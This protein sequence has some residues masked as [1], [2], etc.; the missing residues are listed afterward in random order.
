MYSVKL[1]TKLI[2]DVRQVRQHEEPCFKVLAGHSIG[3]TGKPI[4]DGHDS[5]VKGWTRIGTSQ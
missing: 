4:K 5:H 2:E 1:N 3:K